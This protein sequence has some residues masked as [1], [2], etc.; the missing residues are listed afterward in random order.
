MG[1]IF[2]MRCF[3]C[4]NEIIGEAI[5][6]EPNRSFTSPNSI[7]HGVKDKSKLYYEYYCSSECKEETF[8]ARYKWF[9]E[10]DKNASDSEC[11]KH[12]HWEKDS[13][14]RNIR[15]GQCVITGKEVRVEP[16]QPGNNSGQPIACYKHFELRKS[17]I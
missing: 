11:F 4:K 9:A 16:L 13:L 17:Y 1:A 8:K 2:K 15:V 3:N 10:L 5:K 14:R 12:D 6:T 7:N